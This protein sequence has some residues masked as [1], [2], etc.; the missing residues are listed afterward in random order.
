V[1]A[2]EDAKPGIVADESPYMPPPELPEVGESAPRW[3][4]WYGP[5]ALLAGLVAYAMLLIVIEGVLRSAGGSTKGAGA[6]DLLT[7]LQDVVFVATAVGFASMTRRAQPWHFGLR[8]RPL[9]RTALWTLI[10]MLAYLAFLLVYNFAFHPHGKQTV[11]KDL[12]ANNGTAALIGGALV[13]IVVVPIAEELF[14]R[15]FFYRALRSRYNMW[16]AAAIDGVVFGGVHYTGSST[17]TVLPVLAALGFMFCL[18]YERTGTIYATIALHSLNNTVAYGSG[19]HH[20]G[21]VSAAIG[22]AMLAAVGLAVVL[23]PPGRRARGSPV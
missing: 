17:L 1:S 18:V 14:F 22:A 5:V 23:T 9:G 13:V 4:A 2:R 20:G 16:V 12:G 15:G 11:T 7:V 19:V 3:P 8:G 10:G 6:A 21:P